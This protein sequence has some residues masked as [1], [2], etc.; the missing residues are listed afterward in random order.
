MIDRHGRMGLRRLLS[1]CAGS[2]MRWDPHMQRH[3]AY[4]RARGGDAYALA[5]RLGGL[6]TGR[7]R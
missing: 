2:A 1:M 6:E 3:T 4:S 5:Y 7:G